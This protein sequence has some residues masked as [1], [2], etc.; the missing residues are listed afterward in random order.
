MIMTLSNN[1]TVS[2]P[3]CPSTMFFTI[4]PRRRGRLCHASRVMTSVDDIARRIHGHDANRCMYVC[5]C[6]VAQANIRA[7]IEVGICLLGSFF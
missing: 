1:T 7:R 6:G 5:M 2:T 3:T 4:H